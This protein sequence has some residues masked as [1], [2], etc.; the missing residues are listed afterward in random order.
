MM[1]KSVHEMDRRVRTGIPG[2]D[3]LLSGGLAPKRTVLIKGSAGSGKTTLG[4]QMLVAGAE[5]F[6]EPGILVTFE[7]MPQQLYED[8]AGFGWDLP[9]LHE[10]GR[11]RTVFI[12]PEDILEAPGRQ[13]NRLLV[14]LSDWIDQDGSKRVLIDS[15]SHLI[16]LFSDNQARAQFLEFLIQLKALGLTPFLTSEM[17]DESSMKGLDAYLVDTILR[18]HHHIRDKTGNF[19]RHIEIIKTRGFSHIQGLHPMEINSGGIQ[20]YPRIYPESPGDGLQRS[21]EVRDS[22]DRTGVSGL[23]LLLGGGYTP[24][25][26]IRIA[27]LSGTYKTT[28][29][30]HFI[31]AGIDAG[32][33]GLWISFQEPADQLVETQGRRGLGLADAVGKGM[34]YFMEPALGREPYEKIVCL[35]EQMINRLE[36]RRLVIDGFDELL[37][38]LDDEQQVEAASWI[39]QRFRNLG[40]TCLMIQRISRVTG[41]NPLSEIDRRTRLYT[42]GSWRL[43]VAWKKS[44][45]V[46]AQG[47]IH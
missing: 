20:V 24:G 34:L 30:T 28:L 7:Q 3:E 40:V 27:G 9:S 13:A 25:S 23:D 29:A 16:P 5:Q 26:L 17:T 10:A 46:E 42:L 43:R 41:R 21:A 2:L 18:L 45:R 35:A 4:I 11:V 15:I 44:Y 8:V 12:S 38:N 39:R 22:P 1:A 37:L 19:Q 31:M 47:G 14:N 33:P 36:I 32:E 6:D